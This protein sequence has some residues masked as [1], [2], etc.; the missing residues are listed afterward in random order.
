MFSRGRALLLTLFFVVASCLLAAWLLRPQTAIT[1]ENAAKI[2]EGMTRA[3]VEALLG[4]P[5]RDETTG[6]VVLDRNDDLEVDLQAAHYEHLLVKSLRNQ[7]AGVGFP[8]AVEWHSNQVSILVRF[9]RAGC[10]TDCNSIPRRRT[11][12]SP[13][14]MVRRWLG[15]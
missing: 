14:D 6:P 15:L 1:Q 5:A 9:N 13:L 10:V 7:A 3:E 12:E 4:G 11:N 2:T 8:R